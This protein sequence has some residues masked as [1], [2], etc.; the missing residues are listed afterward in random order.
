MQKRAGDINAFFF[1]VGLFAIF[2]VYWKTRGM[3]NHFMDPQLYPELGGGSFNRLLVLW[4]WGANVVT[5]VLFMYLKH[6]WAVI[7]YRYV[8]LTAGIAVIGVNVLYAVEGHFIDDLSAIVWQACGL[9]VILAGLLYFKSKAAHESL[10]YERERKGRSFLMTLGSAVLT[11]A[12]AT[13]FL[14]YYD[15]TI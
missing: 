7:W 5:A 1:F 6:S 13:A 10:G 12:A 3:F 11:I 9:V 8:F 14:M 4:F 2:M 15:H